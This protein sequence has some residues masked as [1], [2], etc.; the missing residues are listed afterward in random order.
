MANDLFLKR[1]DTVDSTNRY[2][3]DE[4]GTLWREACGRSMVAVTALHQTA[5]RGQRGNVWA[6]E[7]GG[8]LLLSILVRPG[9][10][11]E[12]AHQFRLSQAVAVALQAAMKC[13][14]ID[15]SL[16]WPNDIYVGNRKLAGILVELD[17][18]GSF[19]EQAI[20]G[21]G[22]NVNQTEFPS[23]DRV[24]VSM[25]MLSGKEFTIDEVLDTVLDLFVHY[26]NEMLIC[27]ERVASEY[28]DMLLGWGE[29]RL[30]N[31]SCGIF[32]AVVEGVD[33]GGH[34]LLRRDNGLLARYAFKEV[35]M[36]L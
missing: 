28:C 3:R 20:I 11:L 36:Q 33:P 16:K 13:Y 14:G 9:A 1:L 4:A 15:A 26:Y 31:D 35:E 34:L 24:P 6:S 30:F 19:V 21:I 25:K 18:S 27:P 22:L 8:N 23:M 32:K 12:V 29:E 7:P 2:V 17:Y 10:S 5:G